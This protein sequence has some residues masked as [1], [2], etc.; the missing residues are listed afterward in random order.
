MAKGWFI[1]LAASSVAGAA[2]VL[3]SS[4]APAQVRGGPVSQDGGPLSDI[5]TNVGA[6]SR[7][8]HDYG[9]NLGARS[10]GPLGGNPVRESVTGDVHTGPVSELSA[11]SVTASRPVSGGGTVT[12][13]SAGAVTKNIDSPI[14]EGIAQ[15]LRDLGPLQERMR[16]IQPIPRTTPL[17][18]EQ[19]AETEAAAPTAPEAAPPLAAAEEAEATPAASSESDEAVA[20]GEPAEAAPPPPE[21]EDGEA[22]PSEPE[23]PQAEEA[24]ATP[25]PT[26]QS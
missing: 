11:G 20:P 10:A 7:S 6:G 19:A 13:S 23:E 15:P 21:A 25:E 16:A 12:D 5:S 17:P 14:R 9:G 18:S 24:P 3:L 26:P 8:V 1:L 2:L 22:E 4:S